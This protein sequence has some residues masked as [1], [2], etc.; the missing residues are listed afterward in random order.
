MRQELLHR[1]DLEHDLRT[2]M[3]RKEFEVHGQP[4]MVVHFGR[5]TGAKAQVR[6]RR[7]N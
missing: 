3:E 1:L 6:W 2:A 7:V 4:K 5:F